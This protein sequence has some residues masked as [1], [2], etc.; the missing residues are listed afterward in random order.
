MDRNPDSDSLIDWVYWMVVDILESSEWKIVYRYIYYDKKRKDFI[1]LAKEVCDGP[2]DRYRRMDAC[3]DFD[4]GKIFIG[5]VSEG[6]KELCLFHECLEILFDD[7]KESYYVPG[8]WGLGKDEDPILALEAATWGKLT[9]EQKN[10]IKS[11]LP[12][13]P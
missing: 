7:W 1:A 11:F 3:V 8:L 10:R 6:E 13:G 4:S 9:Q 2:D 5:V 12:K